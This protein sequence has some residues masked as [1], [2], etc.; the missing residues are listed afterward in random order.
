MK[1]RGLWG[2][3][4]VEFENLNRS[5]SGKKKG[6]WEEMYPEKKKSSKKPGDLQIKKIGSRVRPLG[7]GFLTIRGRVFG[8]RL[9]TNEGPS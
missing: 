9:G 2:I 6:R 1:N 4:L 3:A 8:T 5:S 7:M